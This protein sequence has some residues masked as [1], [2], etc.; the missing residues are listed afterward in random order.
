[1]KV[2][3]VRLHQMTYGKSQLDSEDDIVRTGRQN[4]RHCQQQSYP[5]RL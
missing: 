1:M 4:V 5:G 3:A 2:L